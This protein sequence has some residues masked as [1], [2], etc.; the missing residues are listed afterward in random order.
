MARHIF[1]AQLGNEWVKRRRWW[2]E[3]DLGP[4]V[5]GGETT[6]NML[7]NEPVVTLDDRD[8]TRTDIL[9]EYFVDVDRFPEFL[10]ACRE[11][12]P[13]SYQEMLNITLRYVDT[14]AESLLSYAPRPRI[15]CV[16]LFS[17]EMTQRSEA[18]MARMTAELIDRVH[19]IGGSYYLP[20]RPHASAEQFAKGYPRAAEFAAFKRQVDPEGVFRT[21][22][23]TRYLENM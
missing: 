11:V 13:A 5:G 17:Q 1:R 20:Y 7:I 16:M 14:D 15:A 23:W 8:P 12:I 9:H 4:A 10:T 18:D 3:T 22:F 2:F 6:R 19:A 21:P